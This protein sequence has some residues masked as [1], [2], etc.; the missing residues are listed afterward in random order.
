MKVI[1]QVR[2]S[3]S[4]PPPRISYAIARLQQ[5]VLAS[6]SARVAPSH[7]TALQFTT[8]SVLGRHGA[9]LSNSQLAR[10]SF[11]TPQSMH[12]VIHRLEHEGLISRDPHPTYRRRLPA[13]LTA[14]GRRVLAACEGEVADFEEHMLRGFGRTKRA[15]FLG[16]IT[17]AIRNLGGGFGEMEASSDGDS[18]ASRRTKPAGMTAGGLL[19]PSPARTASMRRGRKPRALRASGL[20]GR[21]KKSRP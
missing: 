17:S 2:A 1:A 20:E 12:E 4:T 7:L 21:R 6:V 13:S 8:L 14:K 16:M 9:P 5:L 3:S 10:R 19:P 11:M 15:A 18:T